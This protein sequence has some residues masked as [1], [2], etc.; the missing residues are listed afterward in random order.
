MADEEQAR[1]VTTEYAMQ[2]LWLLT[3]AVY[4]IGGGELK[5][6]QYIDLVHPEMQIRDQRSAEQIKQD[7]LAKLLTPAEGKEEADGYNDS[8]RKADT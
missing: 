1:Q 6:P 5:T 7:I 4:A 2:H 8:G 3:S